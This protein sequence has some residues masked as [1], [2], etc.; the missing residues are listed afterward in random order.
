MSKAEVGLR[1]H[2]PLMMLALLL[3]GGLPR[4]VA[5]LVGWLRLARERRRSSA[6]GCSGCSGAAAIVMYAGGCALLT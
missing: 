6:E 5:G 2:L 3:K 4:L 1:A